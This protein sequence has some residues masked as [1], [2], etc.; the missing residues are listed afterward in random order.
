MEWTDSLWIF[1]P[2]V[3][4]YLTGSAS[5]VPPMTGTYHYNNFQ[6]GTTGHPAVGS[7]YV[8]PVF[9]ETILRLTANTAEH[10]GENIY[11]RNGYHNADGTMMFHWLLGNACY[12]ISTTTGSVLY[13]NIPTG[14]AAYEISFDP[15]DPDAY[16]YFSG[17]NLVRRV[18]STSTNTTIHT[19]PA[20]LE[21]LGGSVD[22]ISANGRY[23]SLAWNAG[24][25]VKI[26]VYDKQTDTIY[27]GAVA[28]FVAGGGWAAITP[29]ASHIVSQA[30]SAAYPNQEHHSFAI[31]HGTQTLSTTAVQFCG[32]TGDHG[33]LISCTDGKSYEVKPNSDVAPFGMYRWDLDVSVA[34]LT[35]TQQLTHATALI[36][37]SVIGDTEC[38]ISC[39]STGTYQNWCFISPEYSGDTFD[40]NP[41]GAWS[42]YRQEILAVNVLTLEVRRLAHHR[43]R[44]TGT[45]YFYYPRACASWNG[46][47]V[48]WASNFNYNNVVGYADL[49][50]IRSPLGASD[51]TAPTAPTGVFIS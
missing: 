14:V 32:L 9:S 43:S 28:G 46:N 12:V 17:A 18:L 15:L 5:H 40:S 50:A 23:F 4:G 24:D 11:G 16:Y 8:D 7:T 10:S 37:P 3:F 48:A 42:N 41:T 31:N 30:G 49:Y 1:I 20:A 25:G 33:D 19:F 13:S 47:V 45:N 44:S 21:T 38:H 6:P 34:G 36:L 27:T 51:S 29:N 35:D 22:W 39:V 2:I 26:R